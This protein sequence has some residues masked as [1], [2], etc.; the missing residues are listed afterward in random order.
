MQLI[1]RRVQALRRHAGVGHDLR[2]RRTDGDHQ[3]E[4]KPF[5]GD[6]AV[7]GL[8][9]ETLGALEQLCRFRRQVHLAG[10]GP[11]D[12]GNFAKFRLD[13]V[14][15]V[16]RIAAGGLDEAGRQAFAIVEQHLQDVKGRELLMVG[17]QGQHLCRLDEAARAL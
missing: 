2:R 4:E 14:G 8:V 11:F 15:S 7:A 13:P 3:G 5:R 17:A 10:A 9:G 6:E 12:A 16:R 1:D